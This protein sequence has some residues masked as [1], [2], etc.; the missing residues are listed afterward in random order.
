[1]GTTA[2]VAQ[3]VATNPRTSTQKAPSL[4]AANASPGPEH[5][6][7]VV[8]VALALLAPAAAARATPLF[9]LAA[10]TFERPSAEAAATPPEPIT[11]VFE[12]SFAAPIA[13]PPPDE[14]LSTSEL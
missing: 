11:R 14:S 5:V 12:P 9:T 6:G 8:V 13:T 3:P 1:M 4:R 2:A 7:G 10:C